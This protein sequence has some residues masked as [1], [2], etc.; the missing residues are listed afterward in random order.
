MNAPIGTV[1]LT[2]DRN[3]V[4]N[5]TPEYSS[6]EVA[7]TERS[8][9]ASRKRT[10]IGAAHKSRFIF[11]SRI[12]R[13]KVSG[14]VSWQPGANSQSA[15]RAGGSGAGAS[16][17]TGVSAAT[18]ATGLYRLF[19]CFCFSRR[20]P[21]NRCSCCRG[22]PPVLFPCA[23]GQSDGAGT[24]G[25]ETG[26]ATFLDPGGR[27]REAQRSG[28]SPWKRSF[29]S[30]GQDRNGTVSCRGPRHRTLIVRGFANETC[31]WQH[32]GH[33]LQ[34][35]RSVADASGPRRAEKTKL[36]GGMVRWIDGKVKPSWRS[37]WSVGSMEGRTN[38]WRKTWSV[39]SMEGSKLSWR[40]AWSVGSMERS[41]PSWRT[42]WS[43][44]SMEGS[45][46]S[47]RT[48]WSVG[49]DEKVKPSW[50][51]LGPLD[52]W[53]G[54]PARSP[55]CGRWLGFWPAPGFENSRDGLGT[56]RRYVLSG[57]N[58]PFPRSIDKSLNRRSWCS[59]GHSP[60]H[61]TRPEAKHTESGN[62]GN[63]SP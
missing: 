28:F 55:G 42:A 9:T 53:K 37:A 5:S 1:I 50:R 43:V 16:Q 38:L 54:R 2:I 27:S 61:P 56:T 60:K 31:R 32:S 57:L 26:P 63:G 18:A 11:A 7:I 17:H 33:R 44:G 49:T 52:R 48:A 58:R 29:C 13:V 39:G 40:A 30:S 34:A 45:K 35:A 19:L 62:G 15:L 24:G 20:S 59:P 4:P 23:G 25:A 10:R 12:S 47:W 3:W 14:L 21:K 6:R 41:K 22:R 8:G 46:P 51:G 36:A